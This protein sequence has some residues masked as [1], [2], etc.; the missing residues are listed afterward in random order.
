MRVIAEAF[1]ELLQ[2]LVDEG[3]IGDAEHPL[4]KLS[5]RR[6][7]TVQQQV[8]DLEKG[9][10]LGQLL[11]GIAAVL[12]NALVA[13]DNVM[14]LRQEAVLTK[15]GS[16]VA[17]PGSPSTAICLRSVARIVPSLIAISYSRPVRLSRMLSESLGGSTVG[18]SV[19]RT[20]YARPVGW[21]VGGHM[22]WPTELRVSEASAETHVHVLWLR[23]T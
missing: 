8:G 10:V 17:S 9:R 2:V 23:D 21:I 20:T 3:V 16:Y 18:V 22:I 12:E 4:V 7:L 19:M 1:D 5:L 11:D 13:V 14:A 15:P 6:Q